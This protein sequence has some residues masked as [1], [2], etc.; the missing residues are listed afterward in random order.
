LPITITGWEHDFRPF[1]RCR[2]APAQLTGVSAEPLELTA[3]IDTGAT[4]CHIRADTQERLGLP[5][6]DAVH[7]VNIGVAGVMPVT[8][9][10]VAIDGINQLGQSQSFVVQGA[11]TFI[12]QF[13]GNMEIILGMNVLRLLEELRVAGGVPRLIAPN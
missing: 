5:V 12:T 4:D 8:R 10:D 2:I 1:V 7:T 11:R 9:L 3:L 6:T 13:D